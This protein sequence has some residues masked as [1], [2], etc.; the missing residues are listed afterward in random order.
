MKRL[1]ILL[2]M[3][4]TA[5]AAGKHSALDKFIQTPDSAFRYKLVKTVPGE[6]Y[7]AYVLELISQAWRTPETSDRPLWKHWLTIIKPEKVEGTT[8]FLFVTGGSINSPAPDRPDSGHVETA[9]VSHSVVAEL[10]GVPNEPVTMQGETKSRTEDGIVVYT[11]RKFLQGGDDT[12]PLHFPMAKAAVRAMDAVTK[13]CAGEHVTVEKFFVAGAS[14]RGWTTWL[15]AA[16][17]R[18]VIGIAPLVIDTLNND[19]AFEHHYR[20]YG[21]F[22]PAVKDYTEG[23]IMEVA[24]TPR[25]RTLMRLEDPYSYRERF[26]MPKYVINSAGDQYFLPDSSRFYFDQLPGEKYLRYVPNT[27]HSLRDSDVRQSLLAYYDA[28]LHGKPRP[29]F[30]W[31]FEKSGEIRV[32]CT[33]KPAAVKLWQAANAEKRDFRLASIGKAYQSTDLTDEGGGVYVAR[34]KAPEK[35]WTASFVE[36]TFP[37]GGKYPLKFTTAVRITPDTLPFPAHKP[38]GKLP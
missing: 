16:A 23:G 12:W 7:T 25:Y 19:K 1:I 28:V 13:F 22:S 15:T 20:S 32:E 8:G 30:T 26:T 3:A 10:R 24:G 18:R 21:A 14:K 11:W 6:G 34:I 2:A 5:F 31:R 37:S 36:L 33:D 9:V 35:G 27:D 17:D 29:K 38:S 4:G